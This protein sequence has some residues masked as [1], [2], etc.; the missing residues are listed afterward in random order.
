M[1]PGW[2]VWT[3]SSGLV[4]VL[5]TRQGKKPTHVPLPE[6]VATVQAH[7]V[8]RQPCPRR[9]MLRLARENS[10][11]SNLSQKKTRETAQR[12]F[13]RSISR[14][15]CQTETLYVTARCTDRASRVSRSVSPPARASPDGARVPRL[16]LRFVRTG[17]RATP[18]LGS[19]AR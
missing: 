15:A 7:C 11:R 16:P 12:R 18:R 10:R 8:R 14:R 17:R 4:L 5:K 2:M 9:S 19:R 6:R 3:S 1:C 13:V